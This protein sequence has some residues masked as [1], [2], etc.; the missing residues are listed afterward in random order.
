M[1]QIIILLLLILIINCLDIQACSCLSLQTQYDCENSVTFQIANQ[2]LFDLRFCHW[3]Q[4]KCFDIRKDIKITCNFQG[5]ENCLNLPQCAWYNNKCQTFTKCSD[6]IYDKSILSTSCE[7]NYCLDNGTTCAF[8]LIGREEQKCED[9]AQEEICVK[10]YL[11]Y[12]NTICNWNGT[13]CVGQIISSCS[14]LNQKQCIQA[15][16]QC[17]WKNNTCGKRKCEDGQYSYSQDEGVK[18]CSSFLDIETNQV[19]YC[20]LN[21]EGQCIIYDPVDLDRKNCHA[22]SFQQYAWD[23]NNQECKKCI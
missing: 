3:Q 16:S 19:I 11:L 13:Q 22:Q 23:P 14:G 9:I 10:H 15:N 5:Q 8:D 20:S 2:D 12:K 7:N 21:E 17:S 18:L 1:K 6:Y 4:G